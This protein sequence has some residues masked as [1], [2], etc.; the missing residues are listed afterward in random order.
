MVL[1]LGGVAATAVIRPIH[2]GQCTARIA[3]EAGRMTARIGDRAGKKFA[4]LKCQV[5]VSPLVE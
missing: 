5:R 2:R 3:Q 1:P 4:Q